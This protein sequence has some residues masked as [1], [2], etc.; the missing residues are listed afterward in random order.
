[1]GMK[2]ALVKNTVAESEGRYR[3]EPV[4]VVERPSEGRGS[5][6]LGTV[7]GF[8]LSF[9]LCVAGDGLSGDNI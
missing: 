9:A 1:M 4:I 3:N 6:C 2:P 5:D 8:L 7:F